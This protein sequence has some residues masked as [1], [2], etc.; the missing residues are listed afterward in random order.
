MLDAD[1]LMRQAGMTAHDWMLEAKGFVEERFSEY[2]PEARA[3]LMA[4]YMNGAAGDEIAMYL[5]SLAEA[6]EPLLDV[7]R[8]IEGLADSLRSD[9]PLQGETLGGVQGALQSI[10]DNISDAGNA[11]A[12]RSSGG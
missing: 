1:A 10:A 8:A 3:I 5:R 7:V 12:S 2:P 11:I 6:T 9:H 4:A